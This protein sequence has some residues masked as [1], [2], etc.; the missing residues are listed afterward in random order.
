M[1]LPHL[2]EQFKRSVNP[3]AGS[4]ENYALF[5]GRIDAWPV[6]AGLGNTMG[7]EARGPETDSEELAGGSRA[8]ISTLK[9]C[10]EA[11]DPGT[12]MGASFEGAAL[13]ER[14]R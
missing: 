5:T 8:G 11:L 9:Q 13:R 2:G 1:I 10:G 3:T 7:A 6:L 14:R 4:T 12:G